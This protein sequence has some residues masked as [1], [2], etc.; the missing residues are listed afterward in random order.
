MILRHMRQFGLLTEFMS[1]VRGFADTLS[2]FREKL[3]DRKKEKK[4]FSLTALA[5]DFLGSASIEG[6]HDAQVDVKILRQLLDKIGLGDGAILTS[7]KSSTEFLRDQERLAAET[8]NKATMQ[9]F[10]PGVSAGMITKMAK[11]G[12][13]RDIL[14]EA[15]AAGGESSIRM[16]L[17]EDIGGRPRVTKNARVVKAILEQLSR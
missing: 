15:Y 1:I 8:T 12:I 5:F 6:A 17:G 9:S 2:M 16:L 7:A 4:K 13:S 14:Q 11:A 10:K 3:K